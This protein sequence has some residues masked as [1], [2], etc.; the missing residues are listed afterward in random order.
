MTADVCAFAEL[1]L[2]ELPRP[3]A[4]EAQCGRLLDELT[5][6]GA[7]S[8]APF[9]ERGDPD[10]ETWDPEPPPEPE[11]K[12]PGPFVSLRAIQEACN[13]VTDAMDGIPVETIPAPLREALD[14][15]SDRL[16]GLVLQSLGGT[17]GG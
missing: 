4:A 13:A 6:H 17:A 12:A 3:A 9:V 15:F 16:E 7:S 14:S 11:S 10:A 8:V 2:A 1:R 5:H